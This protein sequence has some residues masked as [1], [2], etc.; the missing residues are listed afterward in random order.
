MTCV[1]SVSYSFMHDGEIFENI[2]PSR[3]IRQGTLS[4]LIYIYY[5]LKA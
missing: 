2:Q 5:V 3:G 4:P 1:K